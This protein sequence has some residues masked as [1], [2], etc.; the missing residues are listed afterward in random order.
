MIRNVAP[1]RCA[2]IVDQLHLLVD[3]VRLLGN[4]KDHTNQD[5][6]AGHALYD[7]PGPEKKN[8]SHW[9][10][11]KTTKKPVAAAASS[12]GKTFR[13]HYQF[14]FSSFQFVFPLPLTNTTPPVWLTS[15]PVSLGA[16]TPPLMMGFEGL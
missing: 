16:L 6:P 8:M 15:L 14:P 12:T 1:Y 2:L 4:R 3:F 10:S 13:F 7:A 11:A 5:Q 9:K